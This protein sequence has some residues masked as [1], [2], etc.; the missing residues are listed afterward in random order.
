M[1]DSSDGEHKGTGKVF[2]VLPV[3]GILWP[4]E[5]GTGW[6]F[7]LWLEVLA[8]TGHSASGWR[9]WLRLEVQGHQ[10]MATACKAQIS[11]LQVSLEGAGEQ[12][13]WFGI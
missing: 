7:Q 3:V 13:T 10:G 9:G 11:D 12:D 1:P 4:V 6:R 5:A 8:L 2:A